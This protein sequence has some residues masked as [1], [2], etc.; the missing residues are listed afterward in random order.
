MTPARAWLST[1][2]DAVQA[3][4]GHDADGPLVT[5]PVDDVEWLRRRRCGDLLVLRDSRGTR[6]HWEVVEASEC[7]CLVSTRQTTY[8]TTGLPLVCR[9]ADG[10][11]IA[12]VGLLPETEQVHR[13]HLGDTVILTRS[14]EPAVPT[15]GGSPHYIGCTLP[16]AFAHARRA[17]RVWLDDGKI[18]GIIK[19]ASDTE[20]E[21]T[22]T[23]VRPGGANLKAGK[24][25]N[26][27]DTDLRLDALTSKDLVD[28][29][30]VARHAD[31]VNLSFV[32]RPDD[33]ERLQSELDRLEAPNV[34][35][36]LKIENVK[37]FENLPVLLLTAMR[38]P[39]IG[40][41]IARGDLAVEV[42]FERLAEVQE[43]IMWACEAAHVPVIWAT[44]VLDTLARTGQPSRAEVTDAAMSERAE[45]VMLNKGPYIAD[46]IEALDSIL[47]RMSHHQDK[48]RSLLRR[49]HSWDHEAR[50][51]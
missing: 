2:G 11:D 39:H 33:V 4:K 1:P 14:L 12:A 45:C 34:G 41:M 7:R 42:G 6:R 16:E 9:T 51:L 35:I 28:L 5:V 50:P 23:D 13:V 22:V 47:T 25:I 32:R 17:E 37:A 27:P 10:D 19:R 24:G 20:I 36:V 40:V 43:E 31:V 18:G 49:L 46:A 44:Q 8:V 30:F 48:K 29:A 26:L 3:V 21:L 15:P 38:S